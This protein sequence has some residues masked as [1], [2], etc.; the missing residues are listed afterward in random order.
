MFVTYKQGEIKR[1]PTTNPPDDSGIGQ[2]TA[3]VTTLQSDSQATASV[4]VTGPDSAK[5]FNFQF[6]IPKGPKGEPGPANA[7]SVGTVVSGEAAS[8]VITGDAPSQTLNLVLPK[9]DKGDKGDRG[10]SFNVDQVG[11]LD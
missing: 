3:S 5:E 7:L 2:P 6:G 11:N 8:A 9:G 10:E 4:T 1:Y